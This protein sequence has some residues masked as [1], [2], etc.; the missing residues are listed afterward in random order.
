MLE[1]MGNKKLLEE[2]TNRGE[3]NRRYKKYLEN[4][5]KIRC[6]R[7]K[8]H[9][10]EN[11]EEK[12]YGGFDDLKSVRFPN[13]KLVSKN[14]KQWMKKHIKI[15]TEVSKISNKIYYEIEF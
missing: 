11:N 15:K 6:T 1:N 10:N 7:C 9:I 5:G 8:Y 13:W 2:T 3:F 12:W 14:R 4:V